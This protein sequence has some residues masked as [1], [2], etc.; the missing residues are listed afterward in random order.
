[1]PEIKIATSLRERPQNEQR[2]I[3]ELFF[4]ILNIKMLSY[5]SQENQYCLTS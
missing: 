2:S 5:K 1:M 3:V 4:N